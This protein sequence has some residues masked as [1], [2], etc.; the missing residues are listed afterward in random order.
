LC[1][2]CATPRVST[3]CTEHTSH[4]LVRG[5]PL[6]LMTNPYLATHYAVGQLMS[7]PCAKPISDSA[8]QVEAF[9]T[10]RPYLSSATPN[11]NRLIYVLGNGCSLSRPDSVHSDRMQDIRG[12]QASLYSY[13]VPQ[14]LDSKQCN[15][16]WP[17]FDDGLWAPGQ[18]TQRPRP[19]PLD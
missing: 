3:H 13:A 11:V 19:P 14:A 2:G 6:D 17:N 5:H 9:I 10:N 18:L 15:H 12:V 16:F 8:V 1:C 4:G 7:S